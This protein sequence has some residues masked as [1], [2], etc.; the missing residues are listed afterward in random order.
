MFDEHYA[1]ALSDLASAY[2]AFKPPQATS[3]ADA[4][5][6]FLIVKQ[7][8][9]AGGPW[10]ATETPYMV[11]PMDMLASR[12][13]EAVCFA[14]PARVGK[15]LSLLL[16]WMAH[17]VVCDP[18]DFLFLSMTQDKAREFSKTDL[19]RAIDNSPAIKEMLSSSS[20]DRN[21][22]D[23]MFKHG[24]WVRVAW[25]TVSNVSG[26]T[27]R[28]VAITDL[29]R[30]PNAENVDGEGPLFSLALKRTTTFLSRGMALVES[31]P[32]IEWEDPN[33]RAATAHEAPPV[34]GVLGIY[35][36]S[37]RRRWY[38]QCP[39]CNDHFEARPGLGLFNLPDD[40]ELNEVVRTSDLRALAR[41]YGRRIICPSCA[42]E[43]P[44][45]HKM[46]LNAGGLW[47]PDNCIVTPQ[48]EIVGPEPSAKIAGYWLGGVA[49]AYQSWE[50]L[51][52]RY[53]QGL[54]DY[55]LTGSEETLKATTNTDQAMPYMSRHLVEASGR[56]KPLEDRPDDGLVRYVVPADTRCVVAAVDV[57]GG[58][59]ARF[60]VQ[61]HAV[62]PHMEQWL[63]DRFEIRHSNREGMGQD[64]APIDPATYAEDWDVLTE[65]LLRSTWR[66]PEEGREI[67]LRL[68]VVDTGG[69]DG[70]TANAY[71]WFRR[72]R[73]EDMA[74]RVMLYKGA[75]TP[76]AP[77]LKLSRVGKRG[78]KDKGDVPLYLCNPNLLSDG[79][80]AG[81]R[82]A[83]PGPGYIHFPRPKHATQNPEG[84]L[85]QAFFD[86]LKAE[87]RGK[88]G[89]WH[90]IRK[91][92]ESFDL[93]RMIRAGMLRLGLD[94]IRDWNA[95][96]A[97]IAPLE[98]NSLVV[99]SEERREM[100][101]NEA[102]EQ[103]VEP[104]PVR[105]VNP[106]GRRP[107]RSAVSPYLR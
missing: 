89:R 98:M 69:E 76:N 23:I 48:G 65:R 27:Y 50:S 41:H 24:M 45:S 1:L 16:G 74:D 95:V 15:T 21:T 94:K 73:S 52:L 61:I 92:N 28:Y 81:L 42:V 77:I 44:Y 6:K 93:C 30:I 9:M 20:A 36:R 58:S 100:K 62:G 29:D 70:A 32:G 8:G 55:A 25:P 3:V 11:E 78:A 47:V 107:R 86:E 87:Q 39:D 38:W 19:A 43:I 68:L 54:Q 60:V 35:N 7:P 82:R 40:R 57:Q 14:G 88:D 46:S 97:W 33:W 96:P 99:T 72:V 104:R 5:A 56:A 2:L 22:H 101:E 80:D 4:A 63:V 84:W 59:T 66:T 90:Q 49:A 79:V 105:I 75:N 13:H 53:L 18:G 37:D 67:K 26:S 51:V 102:V 85:P 71:G 103:P 106:T 91:R 12:R 64:K 10:S 31:S 34:T 83:T 17:A